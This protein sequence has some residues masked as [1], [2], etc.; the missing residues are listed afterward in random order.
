MVLVFFLGKRK[1]RKM[2]S[3]KNIS[4]DWHLRNFSKVE[5]SWN[6]INTKQYSDQHINS[7][8]K[9]RPHRASNVWREKDGHGVSSVPWQTL[10]RTTFLAFF[11]NMLFFSCLNCFGSARP[12]RQCV[13]S[14]PSSTQLRTEMTLLGCCWAFVLK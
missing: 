13:R 14:A 6:N 2:F 3:R 7:M 10:P 12:A 11:A 8:R 1:N 5:I 4:L 9:T